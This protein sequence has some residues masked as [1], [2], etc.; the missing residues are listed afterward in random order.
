M[1][2]EREIIEINVLP[3]F[4]GKKNVI[5]QVSWAVIFED[6]GF[7]SIARV[8]TDFSPEAGENPFRAIED[9]SDEEI[10]NMCYMKEG[11]DGFINML[12]TSHR[13]E[14]AR[15]KFH[16]SLEVYER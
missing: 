2:I 10:L 12:A 13:A 11:A 14:I 4:Q 15:Q 3:E 6:E 5:A 9:I 1:N 16:S 7:E 8:Q